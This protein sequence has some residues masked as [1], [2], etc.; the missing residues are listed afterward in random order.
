M[1]LFIYFFKNFVHHEW[2]QKFKTQMKFTIFK[3]HKCALQ[4][5]LNCLQQNL[6]NKVSK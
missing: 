1:Q 4:S 3:R 2:V 5:Q 6:D